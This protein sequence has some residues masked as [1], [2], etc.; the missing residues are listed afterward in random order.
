MLDIPKILIFSIFF[1][2]VGLVSIAYA[3]P[4]LTANKITDKTTC[5]FNYCCSDLTITDY[6]E[7]TLSQFEATK[8]SDMVVEIGNIIFENPIKLKTGQIRVCGRAL[9][10]YNYFGIKDLWDSTWWNITCGFKQNITISYNGTTSPILNLSF[11]INITNNTNMTD[12]TNWIQDL[13][14]VNQT[15]GVEVPYFNDTQTATYGLIWIK[16]P[17][18][19]N[20]TNVTIDMYYNCSDS[21]MPNGTNVFPFFDDFLGDDLEAT[22]ENLDSQTYAVADSQLNLTGTNPGAWKCI[23][24]FYIFPVPSIFGVKA[25]ADGYFFGVGGKRYN[26][27]G[28]NIAFQMSHITED[29]W[30]IEPGF[31][32]T[33]TSGDPLTLGQWYT[34]EGTA[35]SGDA[36]IYADHNSTPKVETAYE[37]EQYNVSIC[38][39]TGTPNY[40]DWIYVRNYTSTS[41]T[42]T[43]G[44]VE[45][46]GTEEEEEDAN[47]TGGYSWCDDDNVTLY[48][49][50]QWL[51]D[52]ELVNETYVYYCEYGCDELFNRCRSNPLMELGQIVGIIIGVI[53]LIIIL[54]KKVF[55]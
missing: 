16:P 41:A 52:T 46:N 7:P 36:N 39:A 32:Y 24:N 5:I 14:F 11:L 17:I 25:K 13:Y 18:I 23:R 49:N 48:V 4:E 30:R 50:T 29:Q 8:S 22:W 27:G 44:G 51:N 3:D 15:D 35:V 20:E 28:D 10:Q 45:V 38:T 9:E 19:S 6:D 31:G 54:Y 2:I 21:S 53:I 43:L 47:V 1:L 12:A 40:M 34:F 37:F 26:E 33:G 42:Y 55:R